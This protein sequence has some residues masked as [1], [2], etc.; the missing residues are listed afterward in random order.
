M[1][2]IRYVRAS[3]L[4]AH[5]LSR[6]FKFPTRVPDFITTVIPFHIVYKIALPP[7]AG[8]NLPTSRDLNLKENKR[9]EFIRVNIYFQIPYN[10]H[11]FSLALFPPPSSRPSRSRLPRRG[12]P[13]FSLVIIAGRRQERIRGRER[14][15]D[16]GYHREGLT[17]TRNEARICFVSDNEK[18]I[19]K[20]SEERVRCWTHKRYR[21]YLIVM[22]TLKSAH[23]KRSRLPRY[24]QSQYRDKWHSKL[25]AR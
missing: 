25:S 21:Y 24:L 9:K 16:R 10:G 11:Y 7:R 18:S 2:T 15:R 1:L 3:L 4:P 19:H 5:V 23:R 22:R 20:K 6:E 8:I 14:E 12:R 17:S 13:H